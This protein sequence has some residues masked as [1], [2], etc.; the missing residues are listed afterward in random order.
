ML[1]IFHVLWCFPL[2]TKFGAML[3]M[4]TD[5]CATMCLLVNLSLLYP[6]YTF[7]FQ[8]SMCLDITSHWLHLHRYINPIKASL[9]LLDKYSWMVSIKKSRWTIT[10]LFTQ[11]GAS[12]ETGFVFLF[13]LCIYLQIICIITIICLDRGHNQLWSHPGSVSLLNHKPTSEV[14]FNLSRC[15]FKLNLTCLS[16]S[17]VS[18]LCT[19][20]FSLPVQHV[21]SAFLSLSSSA[22]R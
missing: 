22:P 20:Y 21:C 15:C 6:S 1:L 16:A 13:F 9:L 4:L 10:G 3:D 2:A 11:S 14:A 12:T 19:V 7:L 5:R 18:L 8:L 17:V